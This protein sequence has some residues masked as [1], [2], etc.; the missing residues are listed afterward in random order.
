MIQ[1]VDQNINNFSGFY[2]KRNDYMWGKQLKYGETGNIRLLRL[3]KKDA[4]LWQ[5]MAHEK[6][7]VK[8]AIGKLVNPISH[9][10]HKDLAEFLVEI[11]FYTDI[12]AKELKLK[13][14]RV[15]SLSILLYPIGKFLFNFFIKRGFMDGIR[16]LIFAITMSLHSF[17]VRG[18]LWLKNN[19]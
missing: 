13:N 10:P 9:Y 17:L 16:G 6:W 7:Q 8:G 18:K 4:G 2:M 19:E 15:S 12:R 14:A 5:G 11:N 3:A 1:L